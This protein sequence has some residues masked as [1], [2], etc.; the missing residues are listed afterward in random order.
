MFSSK[1]RDSF[2]G[3]VELHERAWGM[4]T[5][6]GRPKLEDILNAPVVTFWYP[7]KGR[8]SRHM[9]VIFQTT[10]EFG[11]YVSQL[12]L[13]SKAKQPDRRLSRVFVKRKPV[14]IKGIK[15]LLAYAD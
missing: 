9:I 3:Y 14:V 11:D 12:V 13:D 2:M 10:Q 5:Y 8:D 4:D 15:L 6:A 1:K 7:N